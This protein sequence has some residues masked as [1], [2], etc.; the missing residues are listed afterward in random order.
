MKELAESKGHQKTLPF[1]F[2]VGTTSMAFVV[3]QLDVS[4]V[5][6]ALPQIS[7]SFAASISEL[8][9]IVDAYTIAFA[10][11]MLSAGGMGDLLGSK[12]LFQFGMLVFGIASA[13]CGLS[14]NPV[15]LVGFRV[16]QGLGSA[17]M[18]PSSLAILNHSFAHHPEQR[19]K[20]VSLW[21][22]AGGASIAA[23]PIL[24]GLLIHMSNWRMIFFV[25]VPFCLIGLLLSIRLMESEKHPN[26]GFDIPGQFSWMLALTALIA[27]IIEYHHLGLHHPLIYG[28]LIFSALMLMAFLWIENKAAAPILPL[29]LFQ[30]ANFNVLIVA[31]SMLNYA[32]YGTVFVLSLYLQDVL[33]YSSLTAGMA[34]LPLTAGFIISN[35]MSSKLTNKYGSRVPILAGLILATAG[36]AGLL[37]AG[38]NT[39]YW[40]LFFPFIAMP[41]GMGLAIPAMTTTVLASV[42]K[43]RSGT[44][45][46]VFNTTRQAAGAMGVAIFGAMTNGGAAGIVNAITVSAIISVGG[47]LVVGALILKYLRTAKA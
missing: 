11:L 44:A 14:W 22:A 10:V 32:Y 4:I 28:G 13:G 42:T 12:R 35:L 26:R 17:A 3:S 46:A 9:W 30:S 6:I 41:L 21:T 2:I 8:Q 23:G 15:S 31:G 38:S 43:T 36:F 47:L 40:Q 18:I 25:N 39:P 5:N 20:A 33:H 7:R 16:L 37:I 1:V 29:G 45:S 24:G 27:A 19:S 34:F